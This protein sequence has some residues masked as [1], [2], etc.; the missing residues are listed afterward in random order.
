MEIPKEKMLYYEQE[1]LDI[2]N[3]VESTYNILRSGKEIMTGQQLIGVKT[4]L[5][6][7]F[8]LIKKENEKDNNK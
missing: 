1:L 5:V 2:I 3:R 8:D 7:L 4:K 6:R